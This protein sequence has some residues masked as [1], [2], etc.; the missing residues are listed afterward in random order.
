METVNNGHIRIHKGSQ[1]SFDTGIY[2]ILNM[3]P[4]IVFRAVF[5]LFERQYTECFKP[6]VFG[7]PADERINPFVR[8]QHI[9]EQVAS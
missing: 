4:D 6:L 2:A 1:P 7:N 9:I 3:M 8:V 5:L